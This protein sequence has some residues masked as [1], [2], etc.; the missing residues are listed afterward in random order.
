MKNLVFT[1]F[2]LLSIGLQAQNVDPVQHT[3]VT[4]RS[5]TWCP[6]CGGW[7]WTFFHDAIEQNPDKAFFFAAHYSGDLISDAAQDI[8]TNWGAIGQPRFFFNET[9]IAASSSSSSAKLAELKDMVDAA[10][11]TT[12]LAGVGLE[13]FWDMENEQIL[14]NTNTKFFQDASGEFYTA[15]YLVEDNLVNFQQGQGNNAVHEKVLRTSFTENSFGNPI[16]TGT[17]AANDEFANQFTLTGYG[18]PLVSN[19]DYE[20]IAVIY[21]LV[22]GKYEVVNVN[23]TTEINE[24]IIDNVQE[25][26]TNG[27]NIYPAVFTNFLTIEFELK[28]PIDQTTLTLLDINGKAVSSDVIYSLPSGYQQLSIQT[29]SGLA[30]GTYF[31][32]IDMDGQKLTRKIIKQ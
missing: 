26:T 13:V 7:G 18:N 22:N 3:L 16:S 29:D 4:K 14:V 12:P 2:F 11:T 21:Q 32:T 5:A 27:V 10:Y 8:T 28:Q 24:L 1:L 15:L 6:P 30:S 19:L 17:I 31:L 20:Y 9:D 23:G 25:I